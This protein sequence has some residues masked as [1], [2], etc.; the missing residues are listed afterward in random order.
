MFIISDLGLERDTA[1]AKS[2]TQIFTDFALVK[3]PPPKQGNVPKDVSIDMDTKAKKVIAN[4][5]I[6][7]L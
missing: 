5:S 4:Y 1:V 6:L 7:L 2:Q 3:M